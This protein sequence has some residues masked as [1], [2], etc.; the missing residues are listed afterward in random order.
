MNNVLS[1]HILI[2]SNGSWILLSVAL[3][4]QLNGFI[5]DSFYLPLRSLTLAASHLPYFLTILTT[6]CAP[7]TKRCLVHLH[8]L[9]FLLPMK[10]TSTWGSLRP[11]SSVPQ[12]HQFCFQKC[13]LDPIGS[14]TY[15]LCVVFVSCLEIQSTVEHFV[16]QMSPSPPT[17]TRLGRSFCLT[18]K[19]F[20]QVS[21]TVFCCPLTTPSPLLSLQSVLD[22]NIN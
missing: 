2:S 5:L 16:S 18:L 3:F 4:P 11:S 20:G 10:S 21:F 19:C 1:L 17:S 12:V 22:K 14:S 7:L 8:T 13:T 6:T 9:R 15:L